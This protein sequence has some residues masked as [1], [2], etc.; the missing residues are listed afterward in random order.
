MMNNTWLVHI[1]QSLYAMH[2]KFREYPLYGP[3]VLGLLT[4]FLLLPPFGGAATDAIKYACLLLA[5]AL[6]LFA[7][8]RG[9][10]GV[11]LPLLNWWVIV[12]VG[13][14][15]VVTLCARDP[16]YALIGAYP[17]YHS[18][19]IVYSA[20]A[21]AVWLSVYLGGGL[22]A[23]IERLLL[24]I[25]WC[26]AA[27][28]LLQSFGIGY[29]GGILST[30]SV[31]PDRVPSLLGNPNFSSWLV[32]V[33]L[34]FALLRLVQ[35]HTFIRRVWWMCY[36]FLSMWSLAIFSSRGAILAAIVGY[37]TLTVCVVV[38][39]QW[40]TAFVLLGCGILSIAL[41]GG[42]YRIYRQQSV[43][44]FVSS[45]DSNV[46]DRYVAWHMA[47][48]VLDKHLW[49]GG[50]P[51][52]FD[53]YFWE[54]LPT[55]RMG[56]DQY[57]DD[58]HNV[59]FAVLADLGVPGFV[60][61]AA[62]FGAAAA[63]VL[64]LF[65]NG[66]TLESWAAAAAGAGAWLVAG[67]FNPTVVALWLLLAV[68]MGII[69]SYSH[70]TH[71]S[72]VVRWWP[73]PFWKAGGLALCVLAIGIVVGEYSLVYAIALESYR[74]YPEA[75]HKQRRVTQLAVRIEPYNMEVRAAALFTRIRAGDAPD[76]LR[77]EIASLFHMHPY[78]ARAGLIAAQL[79]SDLW[80]RDRHTVDMVSADAYLR[81][82][83][84]AGNG[85]PVVESWAAA[86]YWR[87]GRLDLAQR[88]AHYA[89]YKQPRYLEN[90]LLLTKIYS[91]KDNLKGMEW[92]L[93][94]AHALVPGNLDLAK[95]RKVLRDTR[96]VHAVDLRP[97][98][99]S[100]IIRLH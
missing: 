51:G 15:T 96:D 3:F 72:V 30:L 1:S 28:G 61:F 43:S 20:F 94:K 32:A 58:P 89:T 4:V 17:R 31:A 45:Q 75:V 81:A 88:Y 44:H 87:T 38:V 82:A 11:T 48:V 21:G 65:W 55:T 36:I 22:R 57:F 86:Y 18:S 97:N 85:Y 92:A 37:V 19:W 54:Y 93:D 77:L 16:L 52:N 14:V 91:Q 84:T 64:R 13:W 9:V 90:W 78:S 50:G 99:V 49:L 76:P 70:R 23:T 46:S 62:L 98:D 25:T 39:K 24:G 69:F 66:K 79:M 27:F 100:T 10:T 12:F 80:N 67:M 41:F 71:K 47:G 60:L 74:N 59:L 35:A 83:L 26:V 95:M 56:G 5:G 53:Q 8:R 6:V 73:L 42:Y 68:L 34:P 7:F 40:R 29:Y 33:V 2:R 63:V